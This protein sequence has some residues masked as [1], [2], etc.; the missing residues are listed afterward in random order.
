MLES[1][2]RQIQLVWTVIQP[3]MHRD[4]MYSAKKEFPSQKFIPISTHT[5]RELKVGLCEV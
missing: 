2:I 3:A 5:T 4:F 1:D